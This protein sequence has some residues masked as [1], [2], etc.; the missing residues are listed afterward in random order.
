MA[1]SRLSARL[2]LTGAVLLLALLQACASPPQLAQ[3]TA[4]LLDEAFAPTPRLPSPQE[5]L[6]LT[7]AMR[8]FVDRTVL[9]KTR[10]LG[11]QEGLL[12]AL[13]RD[14]R[15]NLKYDA[16]R[17]RTAA[18]TFSEGQG[19]CL[20]LVL[21]TAAFARELQ[22]PVFFR[23]VVVDPQLTRNA[24]IIY[25][26][27]HVNLGLGTRPQERHLG[28]EQSTHI[29]VD[30]LPDREL[31]NSRAIEISEATIVAMYYNNRAAELM[32]AGD[33]KESYWWARAAVLADPRFSGG[34]NSLA[35]IYRRLGRL[36]LAE[37]VLAQVLN[38]EPDN[39][40]ALGNMVVLLREGQR[41]QEMARYEA[42]LAL[43][44]PVPPFK[45]FDEGMEAMKRR[46]FRAADLLFGKELARSA[47]NHEL[48]FWAALAKLGLGQEERAARHLVLAAETSPTAGQQRIYEAKLSKLRDRQ[49]ARKG[50]DWGS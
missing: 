45:Y 29:I 18:E 11:K 20:S 33:F 2:R 13:Y 41:P 9:P 34:F 4:P 21:M 50:G 19:N 24:G 5:L 8:E 44:Q 39:E 31:K 16:E 40:A 28:I 43:V 49:P 35:I 32:H 27:G 36:D 10:M 46:D 15:L 37:Q 23:S 1:L 14:G 25:Q 47:N 3:P 12:Q 38:L 48:H 30:F 6:V 17:T 26:A 7:P 42:R 22:L